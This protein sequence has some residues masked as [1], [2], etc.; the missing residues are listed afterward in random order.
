MRSTVINLTAFVAVCLFFTV[1]LAFTIANIR[2]SHLW[3]FHRDYTLSATFDDVTGLNPGDNVKVAGV[4]VGKVRSIGVVAG[5]ARV[6]VSWALWGFGGVEN[7]AH[8]DGS[9]PWP[10]SISAKQP[11]SSPSFCGSP[12]PMLEL[13]SLPPE[14]SGRFDGEV[15]MV[16]PGAGMFWYQQFPVS[17]G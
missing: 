5:R 16:W 3:F 8:P 6:E 15:V 7:Q 9:Y 13:G 1:Y 2:P 11:L 4:V 12:V 10:A 14:Q 17:V